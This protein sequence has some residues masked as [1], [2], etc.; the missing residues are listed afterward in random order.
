MGWVRIGSSVL[1]IACI[2]SGGS[3]AWIRGV[4]GHGS[5]ILFVLEWVWALV[6]WVGAYDG[7]DGTVGK[8]SY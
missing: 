2:V 1:R 5:P 8:L 4:L 7:C 6:V 3:V